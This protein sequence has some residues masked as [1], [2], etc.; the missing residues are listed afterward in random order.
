MSDPALC[1]AIRGAIETIE[2]VLQASD[3][4]LRWY[5]RMALRTAQTALYAVMEQVGC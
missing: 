5:W 2:Q 1:A 4:S 3:V